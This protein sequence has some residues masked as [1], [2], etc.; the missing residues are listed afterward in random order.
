M[1]VHLAS[2]ISTN[3]NIIFSDGLCIFVIEK[4]IIFDGRLKHALDITFTQ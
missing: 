1:S 4:V 3:L 2:L